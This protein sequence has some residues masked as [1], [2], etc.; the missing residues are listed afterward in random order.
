MSNNTPTRNFNSADVVRVIGEVL[1]RQPKAFYLCA[2]KDGSVDW[3]FAPQSCI[4][5]TLVDEVDGLYEDSIQIIAEWFCV[6]ADVKYEDHA[7]DLRMWE[8]FVA[9]QG[10]RQDEME[11]AY[12]VRYGTA[13]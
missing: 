8:E 11:Q 12:K 2:L 4:H 6:D 13:M 1:D 5:Q 10:R 9:E 7:R 3:F